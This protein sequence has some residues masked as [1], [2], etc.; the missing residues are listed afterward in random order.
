VFTKFN[1]ISEI[2]KGLIFTKA[3]VKRAVIKVGFRG[4][5]SAS[6]SHKLAK[7]FQNLLHILVLLV[8]ALAEL[9]EDL[10]K[11]FLNIYALGC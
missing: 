10:L 2:I 4:S 6:L 9:F 3:F 8:L 1:A 11:F 5:K 7:E